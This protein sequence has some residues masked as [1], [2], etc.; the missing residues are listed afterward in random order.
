MSTLTFVEKKCAFCNATN[1]FGES[2]VS[3]YGVPEGLDGKPA[4][5]SPLYTLIQLCPNCGYAAPDITVIDDETKEIVTS[6]G[7]RNVIES[8]QIPDLVKK[9]IAWALIQNQ[10]GIPCEAARTM[11]FAT[12]LAEQDNNE[13]LTSRC[14][15]KAIELMADCR[16]VGGNFEISRSKEILTLVDLHRREAAFEDAIDIIKTVKKLKI[17]N[18]EDKQLLKY[19]YQLC[20]NR[21]SS[22]AKIKDAH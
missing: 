22:Y 15:H 13:A 3:F 18:E 17:V 5:L 9:Y 2:G 20:K 10:K 19:E 8:T 7:Y 1:Q 16:S 6:T 4:D 21:D 11:L 14:R 12:W